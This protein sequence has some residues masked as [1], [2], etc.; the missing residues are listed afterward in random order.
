MVE[1]NINRLTTVLISLCAIFVPLLVAVV[2]SG[3]SRE[4]IFLS[5]LFL[6]FYYCFQIDS[7]DRFLIKA[8]SEQDLVSDEWLFSFYC[9]STFQHKSTEMTKKMMS[10]D[11]GLLI[12]CQGSYT[13]LRLGRRRANL[14]A[15]GS[16]FR[17]GA[18]IILSYNFLRYKAISHKYYCIYVLLI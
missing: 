17:T 15:S 6:C 13:V 4:M 10:S 14:F 16:G 11:L 5:E 12:R 18:T 1:P 3:F 8:Q 7:T 9:I 2:F